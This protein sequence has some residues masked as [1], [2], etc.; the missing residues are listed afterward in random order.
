VSDD[1][2]AAAD[3]DARRGVGRRCVCSPAVGAAGS[4]E[5]VTANPHYPIKE[6]A[7]KAQR[8]VSSRLDLLHAGARRVAIR[9]VCSWSY[10][11]CGAGRAG[12][13]FGP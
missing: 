4:R 12:V 2:I 10:E 1:K 11:Q 3:P 9:S 7:R 5:R 6:L 13:R 8:R